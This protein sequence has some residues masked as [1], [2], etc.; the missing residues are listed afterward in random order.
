MEKTEP[1]PAAPNRIQSIVSVMRPNHQRLWRV[2]VLAA[3]VVIIIAVGIFLATRG[4][5]GSG[6]GVAHLVV[7]NPAKNSVSVTDVGGKQLYKLGYLQYSYVNYEASSPKGELLLSL[8]ISTPGENFIFASVAKAQTLPAD[9]VKNLHAAIVLDSSHHVFFTDENTVV[10]MDCP[11]ASSCKLVSLNL[12]SAKLKIIA[13]I[14]AKPVIAQ[15]PPAY[16]LGTSPDG[17]TIYIR[18]LLANKLGKYAAGLYAVNMSGKVTASWPLNRDADYTPSLS[19]DAKQV[20]YKTGGN[21]AAINLGVL[22]L[23]T[24]K[25]YQTKWTG[26]EI[27]DNTSALSWSPDSK[28]VLIIGSNSLLP[29][30]NFDSTFDTTIGYLD[31]SNDKLT[32]LQTVKDSAHNRVGSLGFLDNDTIVYELDNSTK[33]Y[34]FSSPA[35]QI[36]KLNI[37]NQATSKLAAPG[38]LKHVIFY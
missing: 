3:F 2:V 19:P 5:S 8:S 6:Q 30:P 7:D 26:G 33:T 22:N 1:K 36:M 37:G 21:H 20:V 25:T 12:G 13:D 10:Y 23:A 18:T 35:I 9:T 28:K 34:D 16:P 29:R 17:K 32:N 27:A 11:A 4:N 31:V 15:L 38:S 24:S 14:G